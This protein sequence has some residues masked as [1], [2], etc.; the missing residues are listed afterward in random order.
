MRMDNPE[1]FLHN[2]ASDPNF[3]FIN[4]FCNQDNDE[5]F[6]FI[7]ESPYANTLFSCDYIDPLLFSSQ[8]KNTGEISIMSLNIQSISAKFNELRDLI[9]LFNQSNCSPDIICLQELWQFPPGAN[10]SLP[11]YGSLVSKLRNEDV[12]G[13]GVGFFI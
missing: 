6:D 12:Q 3:D 5:K 10:F 4:S 1:F 11:G 7:D 2:L 13:G 9:I 8:F